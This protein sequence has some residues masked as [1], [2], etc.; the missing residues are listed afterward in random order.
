[1]RDPNLIDESSGRIPEE[2]R[3]QY[4][5]RPIEKLPGDVVKLFDENFQLRKE[6]NQFRADLLNAQGVLRT[7]DL[8]LWILMLVVTGEGCVI[9]WLVKAFLAGKFHG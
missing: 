5:Q 8:K 6:N 3:R 2:W 9:G 1:M 4:L 7:A